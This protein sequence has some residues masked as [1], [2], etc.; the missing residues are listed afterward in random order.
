[1][2]TK[3]QGGRTAARVAKN[4]PAG[5]GV[6]AKLDD[7]VAELRARGSERVRAGMAR[8]AIP[9]HKALGI[10]VGALRVMAKRLGRN[11][12]LAA[13][14][15]ETDIYEARLLASFVDDPELVT[16][17][18]MDSWCEEFDNW[19]V[20]DTACF[21]LFDRTPHAFRKVAQW[22]ARREEFVKRAAFALLASL[23]VHD[24]G[25]TDEQFLRCLPLVERAATDERNFVMKAVNWALRSVGKR[26]PAL[27]VEALSV[28]KR[29]ALSPD[30]APRWVGKGALRELES[31]SVL[32][33]LKSRQ[34]AALAPSARSTG[35]SRA[36]RS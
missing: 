4:E 18:Q 15:W 12:E 2:A 7:V 23:T 32:R 20:C 28:S 26:S 25:A 33:R 8:Y 13:A 16:A 6:A 34:G 29:L 1:V 11:H 30:A 24:K 31:A 14:L 21:A 9:S 19:A 3:K 36:R 10:P 35:S 22:G 17:A 27:H 5:K